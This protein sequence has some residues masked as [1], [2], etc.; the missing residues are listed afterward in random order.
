VASFASAADDSASAAG[1]VWLSVVTE[2][3]GLAIDVA[4]GAIAVAGRDIAGDV[5]AVVVAAVL[6]LAR[7]P[8]SMFDKIMIAPATAARTSQP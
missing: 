8:G 6:S 3:D 7:F 4:G 1:G 2:V 5:V